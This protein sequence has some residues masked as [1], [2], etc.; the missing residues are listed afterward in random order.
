MSKR[1][2]RNVQIGQFPS[3]E[4]FEPDMKLVGD[5]NLLRLDKGVADHGNM[6]TFRRTLGT[7][8]F[9]IEKTPPV[10]SRNRPEIKIVRRTHFR[11][12]REQDPHSRDEGI[13]FDPCHEWDA[14]PK[15]YLSDPHE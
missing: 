1:R 13:W 5:G 12:G 9:P 4:V 2:C 3:G 7:D 8:G 14:P 15:I 11:I 6:A 10:G